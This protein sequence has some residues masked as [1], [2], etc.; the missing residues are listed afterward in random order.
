MAIESRL[1]NDHH[2]SLRLGLSW[3]EI[4]WIIDYGIDV[5]RRGYPESLIEFAELMANT[6]DHAIAH[7]EQAV[8]DLE[9]ALYTIDLSAI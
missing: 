9:R 5:N 6:I 7:L 4:S 8:S 2:V 3:S 1:T